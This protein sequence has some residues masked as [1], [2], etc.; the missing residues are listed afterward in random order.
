M[1][2]GTRR[3][4]RRSSPRAS[5]HLPPD[6]LALADPA[7]APLLGALT[8]GPT[9]GELA[10]QD[11]ALAMYRAAHAGPQAAPL[12]RRAARLRG[13]SRAS[14]RRVRGRLAVLTTLAVVAGGF[15]AAGYAAVLPSPLQ[16]MAHHYLGFPGA[17]LGVHA[18]PVGQVRRTPG[19]KAGHGADGRARHGGG[20][21]SP[22]TLPGE[23]PSPSRLGTVLDAW[24]ASS[25]GRQAAGAAVAITAAL[26]HDG[27]SVPGSDV[28]LFERP[29][30]QRHR[31]LVAMGQTGR[32]GTVTLRARS[33]TT[34]A[35]FVVIGLDGVESQPV[36]II[37]IPRV[38]L[39]V[40][41]GKHHGREA[42]VVTC[43][44]AVPGDKVL[45]QIRQDARWQPGHGRRWS[46]GDGQVAG[47]RAGGWHPGAWQTVNL[48]EF[49][50]NGMASFG[51]TAPLPGLAYRV[52]L[53]ATAEHG[54]S[55][56]N[57]V[58]IKAGDL[59]WRP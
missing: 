53:L 49:G 52:V 10:G 43:R 33:L 51:M 56:S 12:S 39:R 57:V 22:L 45:L 55:V 48:T 21:S 28:G 18:T 2:G 8:T 40:Q 27:K 7:L 50:K 25:D 20:G 29:A 16:D 41:G 58:V 30:G 9:P 36:T 46:R 23:H 5:T 19:G 1:S 32:H 13:R 26:T 6:E 35:R 37:V 34:N 24:A 3:G 15:V 54:R 47:G 44:F 17:R 38:S 4:S 42:L 14:E 59:P 11:A 31:H